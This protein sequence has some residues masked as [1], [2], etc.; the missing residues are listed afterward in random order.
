MRINNSIKNITYSLLSQIVLIFFGFLTRKIFIVN[1]GIEFLGI[2]GFLTNVLSMLGLAEMGI[3]SSIIYSLYKPL[4]DKDQ[5]KIIALIQLYKKLYKIIALI[6][7]CL[8]LALYPFLDFFIKKDQEVKNLSIIYMIFIFKNI[9]SYLYAYK[10]SLIN[11][12]QK[13]YLLGKTTL[14][15]QILSAIL[16]ISVLYFYKNYQLFLIIEIIVLV[17]QNIYSSKIVRKLYPYIETKVK[18]NIELKTKKNI[19]KNIKAIF[20]HNIGSYCVFGT[21]NLLIS[22]FINI[23]TVGLYSNYFMIINQVN[24]LSRLVFEG[25]ES[26]VGNLIITETKS[27]NYFVFKVIYMINF[28]ISSILVVFLFNLIEPFIVWWLGD[29][30]LLNKLVLMVLLLNFYLNGMRASIGI[31][32]SKGGIFHEDR[33]IPLIES[34][35][36]LGLSI[37]LV[38]YFGLAGIFIGTTISTLSTVFWNV[39]RLV[40]K[41]IFNES[42]L[43][44][45][46]RYFIYGSLTIVSCIITSQ[47]IDYFIIRSSFFDLILKGLISILIPAFLYIILLYKTK[48]FEYILKILINKLSKR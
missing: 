31:F 42:L 34:M 6:V 23:S 48:E 46:Y 13:N 10:F 45:F 5:N 24:N 26:S 25:V 20:L 30:L 37:I 12:D 40:Y 7:F 11:A 8:S 36:N 14:F 1:L 35:I 2:N 18:M 39:P 3:G 38:K 41:N 22:Y 33:Y 17:F 16:K 28:F 47:V 32:K 43:D 4:A 15:F 29:K 44:Y 9:I 27:K 19:I 21:D